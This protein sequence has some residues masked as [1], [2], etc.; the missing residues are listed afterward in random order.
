MP[1]LLP[2]NGGV[3]A[4]LNCIP[5]V[6]TAVLTDTTSHRIIN[7]VE[8][9]FSSSEREK[10]DV[11]IKMV[12]FGSRDNFIIKKG[13]AME[14]QDLKD[15][16]LKRVYCIKDVATVQDPSPHGRRAM[17]WIFMK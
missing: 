6:D 11:S 8:H 9:A 15:Q 16:A 12:N 2:Y 13:H 4:A 1:R 14:I 5:D 10:T 17:T 7:H 3:S